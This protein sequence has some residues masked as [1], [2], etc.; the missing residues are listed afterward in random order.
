MELFQQNLRQSEIFGK[1]TKLLCSEKPVKIGVE[2]PS[3]SQKAHYTYALLQECG[4]QKAVYVAPNEVQARRM[5]EDFQSLTDQKALYLPAQEY[6][7]YD[8]EAKSHELQHRR[9]GVLRKMLYEDFCILVVSAEV[10]GQRLPIAEQ[11]RQGCFS[12]EL[13]QTIKPEL[14]VEQLMAIGYERSDTVQGRGQFAVRGGIFDIFPVHMAN[15]VRM[16]FWGDEIDSLRMFDAASQRSVE[17]LTEIELSPAREVFFTEERKQE[18]IHTLKSLYQG[19][20][21]IANDI[22]RFETD[23]YFPGIDRY[24][25]LILQEYSTVL[26]YFP[27]QLVILDEATAIA[28]NLEIKQRD[29]SESCKNMLEKQLILPQLT[30]LYSG[31]DLF[32][33]Q[34]EALKL[35]YLKTIG[36]FKEE[37]IAKNHCFSIAAR[38]ISGFG[39]NLKVLVTQIKVWKKEGYAVAIVVGN[40]GRQIRMA[41]LL[42]EQGI[43][44]ASIQMVIGSLHKSFEYTR[45]KCIVISDNELF[46]TGVK[47][48]TKKGKRAKGKAIQ[49][50]TD[51]T[52]GDFIV[53]DAHGIGKY[54]GLE[55]V[56]VSGI[57]R[58]YIKIQYSDSGFLFVPTNQMDLV[59]KYIGAEGHAPK[60][61]KLGSGDWT[62]TKKRVKESLK[63]LA[64]ELVALYAK[65]RA[66]KGFAF[67]PDTIWQ[68]EFEEAFP[69]VE[70]EDQL[71]CVEEIKRDME[72]D[73]PME[74]LL[75]GDVGY[76]KTEV[77][78]RAIFKA[79]MDSKQVAVLVPTTVLAQQHYKNFK[80]RF[81][82]F[83]VKVDYICRFRT[84]AEQREIA[85]KVKRGEI[86]VLIGTHRLLQKDIEFKD[87]GLL[88]VDEEQRFGVAHKEKIKTLKPNV[89]ILTLS[90]TP[91]PRTLHMSMVQIRDISLIEEPPEERHPVQTYVM[92]HDPQIIRE[93]IYRELGRKGQVF[94]LY[95]KVRTIDVKAMELQ[96]MVPEARIAVA[97]GQMTEQGLEQVMMDFLAGDYDIL[98][99]T[100]IIESGIDMANVNTIIM[101]DGDHL[102]LAQLY[103][104]RGR[105]GRSNKLAYAYITY[106]KDKV[107]TEFSE[108]RL[109]TIREFTE[110][111]SG[112]KIGG[113]TA[114]ANG[115][116][117]L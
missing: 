97:H 100:T 82:E 50:F 8:V 46:T 5:Y 107:L 98:V 2:G 37:G 11:F 4:I 35:L 94:Y 79:V 28:E 91:I 26:D 36:N 112:F 60:L 63:E 109:Q 62:R 20:G 10:I 52:P 30:T 74:R 23:G 56:T 78:M 71:Q 48:G 51:L 44:A 117:G 16:E 32:F 21:V 3:E 31:H 66:S 13:G 110:F 57:T 38:I 7:L 90:A 93:A 99:C 67:S 72:A 101:E 19:G 43:S 55:Q 42:E 29:F 47:K 84:P 27:A 114:R 61:S 83:P 73:R 95:N 49:S 77:A 87:L 85:K 108:K 86:D 45:E 75:C 1:V 25:P 69:F 6:F 17:E 113:A 39:E 58:D 115:E 65:R 33:K 81:G 18:I 34:M 14:L 96:Q 89:D 116:R 92:E 9:L 54:I 53:H 88:V 15:P 12:V 102:G 70:T 106:R 40:H 22:S 41:E 76:G 80:Q 103:Q 111:G 104:L 64:A 59:Q 105:V 68:T 24:I